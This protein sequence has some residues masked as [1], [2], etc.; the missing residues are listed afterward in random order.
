MPAG[1]RTKVSGFVRALVLS[2]AVILFASATR[3]LIV[4]N[5]DPSTAVTIAANGGVAGT[6]LGTLVP[7]LP[8]FLPLL[9]G[10]LVISR[11][12][13]LAAMAA[14][15]MVLISPAYMEVGDAW[16]V[17]RS[18]GYR[19]VTLL[20]DGEWSR[21]WLSYRWPLLAGM[22]AGIIAL[23]D[24][25]AWMTNNWLR[26]REKYQ[27]SNLR[28]S[29]NIEPAFAPLGALW[30]GLYRLVFVV[31]MTCI[32]TLAFFF[33]V[34][35]YNVPHDSNAVSEIVR[36]PWLAVEQISVGN[37]PVTYVGYTISTKDNWQIMLDDQTRTI[38]FLVGKEVKDRKTCAL[39]KASEM[40]MPL[41]RIKNAEYQVLPLCRKPSGP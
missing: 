29:R 1:E 41:I 37:R 13:S 22:A 28:Q 7:L 9:A 4:S 39:R 20:W 25:P 15:A 12:Y 36:R 2:P 14:G 33:L 27:S 11:K 38:R 6:L 10:M 30:I 8:P 31:V 16:I 18:L 5:Y 23:V 26:F 3:L 32:A 21:I 19:M 34:A 35:M 17:S 40:R 24:P